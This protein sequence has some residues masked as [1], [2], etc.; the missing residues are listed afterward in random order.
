[1]GV[2]LWLFLRPRPGELQPLAVSAFD[3]FMSKGGKL[4][5]D[6]DGFVRYAQVVVEML[7][8]RATDVL[9]VGYFQFRAL[10][11]GT[12]DQKHFRDILTLAPEAAFG[13]LG[14]PQRPKEVVSAEHRFAKRRLEHLSHWKPT[15]GDQVALREAIN[16]RARAQLL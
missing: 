15:R 10:K 4:P 16:R 5:V 3:A 14:S 7:A 13:T 8:R 9:S 6:V 2:T 1:M 11:N 12:M